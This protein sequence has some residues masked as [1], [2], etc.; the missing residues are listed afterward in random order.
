MHTVTN[1]FIFNLAVSDLL[2]SCVNIPFSLVRLLMDDWPL[3]QIMCQFLPFLQ[4]TAVYV[5][6]WTMVT[7]SNR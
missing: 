6:S 1:L 3:G 5:S 4:V 7:I 2:I